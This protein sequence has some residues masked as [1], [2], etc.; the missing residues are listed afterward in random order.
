M[1]DAL[2]VVP[3]VAVIVAFSII[4]AAAGIQTDA[5]AVDVIV[6]TF[7]VLQIQCLVP[8]FLMA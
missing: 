7:T 8:Q 1:N 3:S 5:S 6:A 2:I 4:V